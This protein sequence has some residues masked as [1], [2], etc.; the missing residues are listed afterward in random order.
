MTEN[1][2]I[3]ARDRLLGFAQQHFASNADVVGVFLAGSL[4][5]G[6]ADAYSDIDLRVVVKAEKH[7]WFVEHRLEIPASW[8][9]FLFNEW[10]PG[11]VHC[12]SHFRFFVKIDIFYFS[13]DE[14][15]PSPWYTL[16]VR[17]LFDPQGVVERLVR[18]SA[19]IRFE[20]TEEDLD[21]SIS[22]GLAAAHEAFRRAQRDELVFTETLLD[23][24]RFHII[25]ADDWLFDRTPRTQLFSKY[26]Q[27]G[28]REVVA[29]LRS[30][31]CVCDK[32]ALLVSLAALSELYRTQVI[33][34][35]G[36]F[37][38]SRRLESDLTALDLILSELVTNRG[39]PGG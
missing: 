3:D 16:P 22:K 30:S 18:R 37:R 9:D 8:P 34:L 28:S 2:L 17:I 24:L 11:T 14:L 21:Y 32:K 7:A 29:L 6:V 27:R 13:Q 25:Q 5:A 12:V 38:L 4:A 35:H 15:Q 39:E 10:R 19:G 1:L 26:D 31:F 23:E 33:Q 20:V 36:R